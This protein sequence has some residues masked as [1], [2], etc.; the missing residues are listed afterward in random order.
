M[1]ISASDCVATMEG[2]MIEMRICI[3]IDAYVHQCRVVNHSRL[4]IICV[5]VVSYCNRA[6]ISA[7][8]MNATVIIALNKYFYRQLVRE[9]PSG[10]ASFRRVFGS[11]PSITAVIIY[12]VERTT[13][14]MIFKLQVLLKWGFQLGRT[15]EVPRRPLYFVSAFHLRSIIGACSSYLTT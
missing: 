10:C 7:E 14:Q 8:I 5:T 1:Y 3:H 4:T 12:Y 9:F 2:G 6:M 11:R 15:I 13:V